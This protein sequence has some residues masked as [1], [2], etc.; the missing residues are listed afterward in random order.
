MLK[1]FTKTFACA[2]LRIGY[3]LC[4]DQKL[5]YRCKMHLPEWNVSLPATYAGIAASKERPWLSETS[6]KIRAERKWMLEQLTEL[7]FHVYP[8][9]ANFLFF[10]GEAGLYAHCL[11]Q[12]ILIR[13]CSNYRGLG[14]GSYRV[15]VRRHE[16]NGRFLH[17]LEGW[18]ENLI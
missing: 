9:A 15:C 7:G 3:L 18:K 14:S 12:G 1:A 6:A 13:D 10:T 11:S 4:A 8:G 17:V 5:L 2:G 16:E